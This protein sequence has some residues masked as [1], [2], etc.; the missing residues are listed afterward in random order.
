MH[1]HAYALA[2]DTVSA[3]ALSD[4][5]PLLKAGGVD[6]VFCGHQHVYVRSYP[7]RAG[8]IDYENGITYVVGN[9]GQKFYSKA[10]PPIGI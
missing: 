10:S 6:L 4:W 9:A 2:A 1:H 5:A 7:L 8:Q 3:A